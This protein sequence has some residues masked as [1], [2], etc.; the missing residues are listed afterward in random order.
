MCRGS[1]TVCGNMAY[2]A[3]AGSSQVHSYNSDTE[4]WFVLPECHRE[5]F[6][7]TVASGLVTAVGGRQ[8]LDYTNTLISFKEKGERRKWVEHFPPMPTKR[9]FTAVMCKGKALVVAGGKGEGID[10]LTKVEVM[11]TDTL[12]WSAASSLLHPLNQ[13]T[14]TVCG[15]RV[16]LV[17]G[18]D[19]HGYSTNS[20]LTC[21]LSTLLK[22]R[23]IRAKM[24]ALPLAGNRIVWHTI[25]DLP[26]KASS[27][28]TLN[29]QL[30]AVGGYDSGGKDSNNIYTYNTQNNSWEVISHL[31][32]RRYMCL[33][34][35]LPGNKLM[36]VGGETDAG[37]ID[38][39]EIATLR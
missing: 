39:V 6:T 5:N 29:E 8:S 21:S 18:C 35:V 26:V 34:A 20:V 16:Y 2:F 1:S 4:E 13:A 27:S 25:T 10:R 33:V 3:Q 19:R 11:D 15:D 7:L 17:G 9:A 24:E 23:T 36:V 30:L 22:S 37:P 28:V 32:T 12:Q 31:P 38:K 14:A